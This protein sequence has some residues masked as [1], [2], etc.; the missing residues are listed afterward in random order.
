MADEKLVDN[1]ER[2]SRQ[3]FL[4]KW[5]G[6]YCFW[7]V[8]A[9]ERLPL[10]DLSMEGFAVQ[11]S[12]PPERHQAFDF[13]MQH[14]N[15]PSEICGTARVVNYLNT[16]AGG[17]A[18]CL[19]VSLEPNG[20]ARLEEWLTAHVLLNASVPINEKDAATIV[21]GRSLV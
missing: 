4:A 8:I 1:G 10:L 6:E 12:S 21:S 5:R 3:R 11:A 9:G 16:P 18:G 17:Q 15:V 7:V 20:L 2:R 19:F 13:V 14:A